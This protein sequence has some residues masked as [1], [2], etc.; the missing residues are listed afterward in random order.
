MSAAVD[1]RRRLDR[2]A[3]FFLAGFVVHNVDHVRRTLDG[4][5]DHVVWA[6]TG[7]AMLSA[8]TLTLIVTRHRLGPLVA[9]GAGLY[10]AVGVSATHLL[11]TWGPMSD[12]L[13]NGD[14]DPFTWIAVLFEIVGAIVLGIVG[15]STY[16]AQQS[17]V[18]VAVR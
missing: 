12:S 5:T 6:G 13:P 8:V 1:S 16:R 3:A 7:V 9:A 15:W 11:P 14:V 18:S 10:I 2:A 4:I 17:R